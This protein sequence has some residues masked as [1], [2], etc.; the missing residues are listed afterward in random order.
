MAQFYLDQTFLKFYLQ[1]LF[2]NYDEVFYTGTNLIY[3][4][5]YEVDQ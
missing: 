2:K 1:K 5:W 3:F 4:S